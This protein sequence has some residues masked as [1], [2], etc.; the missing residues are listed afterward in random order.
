MLA[1]GLL[2]LCALLAPKTHSADVAVPL[3]IDAHHL[4]NAVA[5]AL[6]MDA[7]RRATLAENACNRVEI[8][9]PKVHTDEGPL[10][11]ELR[12]V[13]TT[14][15]DVMGECRGPEP[16]HGQMTVDQWWIYAPGRPDVLSN[17]PLDPGIHGGKIVGWT[18]G[19]PKSP[20][21]LVER[22]FEVPVFLMDTTIA[23]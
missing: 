8:A 7:E 6:H 2:L 10:E 12:L 1:C 21:Q 14:A 19:T 11:V 5:L 23:K 18:T 20:P 22:A 9:D 13:V 3:T 15:L 4:D 17:G 16:W